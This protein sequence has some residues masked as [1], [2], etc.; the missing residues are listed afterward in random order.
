MLF[1]SLNVGRWLL[2]VG[3]SALPFFYGARRLTV[4]CLLLAFGAFAHAGN[5]SFP[6]WRGDPSLAGV[7]GAVPDEPV[8]LWEFR[9]GAPVIAA[10]VA[11]DGM[12]F[13]ANRRGEVFALDLAG[14]RKWSRKF[15]ET[16]TDTNTPPASLS[17]VSPVYAGKT[18][19]LAAANGEV[20]ALNAA[21]GQTKWRVSIG[22]K[23][24][25]SPNLVGGM[26]KAGWGVVVVWGAAAGS[27]AQGFLTCL[28]GKD[29]ATLWKTEPF[30]RTD[31]TIAVQADRI[32][33]GAC[34]ATIHVRSVT[35]G[36]E[37]ASVWLGDENQV[38]GG[39]AIAGDLVFSGSR[40]GA[41]HA[42][43]VKRRTNAWTVAGSGELFTIP[44]VDEDLVVYG[45]GNGKVHAVKRTDGKAVWAFDTRGGQAESPLIAGSRV[46]VTADG[47]V[48]ILD[49]AT[50]K[51][52]WSKTLGDSLAPP[53]VVGGM[54]IVASDDGTVAA[55]GKKDR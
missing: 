15:T 39:V 27:Q 34:D 20:L 32:A 41:L 6:T 44:A 5:E 21:D 55:Y 37:V 4:A 54:L 35:D 10:P 31:G 24:Q 25:G 36:T 48:F 40:S 49:R 2:A 13:L 16:A 1:R 23:V 26:G 53:A 3:Y 52:L 7:V 12:I 8:R 46:V 38:A 45:A 47:T 30:V 50:G 22:G 51:K 29:G 33:F 43:D 42:V 17:F 11:G 28:D 19:V 18:L 14:N 9:A